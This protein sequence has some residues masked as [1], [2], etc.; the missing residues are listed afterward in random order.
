MS[1]KKDFLY[2][3][4]LIYISSN[5]FKFPFE[6]IEHDD[7]FTSIRES[8]NYPILKSKMENLIILLNKDQSLIEKDIENE[9]WNLI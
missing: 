8:A 4:S 7:D 5:G 9:V 3:C 2:L 1:I 6:D